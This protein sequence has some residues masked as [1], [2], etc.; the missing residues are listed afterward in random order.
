MHG[1]VIGAW[2]KNCLLR[3]IV[4][5]TDFFSTYVVWFKKDFLGPNVRFKKDFFP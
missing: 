2:L 3:K 5:T 4:G 1:V